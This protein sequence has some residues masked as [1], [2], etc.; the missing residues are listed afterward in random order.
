MTDA[1]LAAKQN[2]LWQMIR[3]AK[4]AIMR[5][6]RNGP[7]GSRDDVALVQAVFA[8]V[9][10]KIVAAEIEVRELERKAT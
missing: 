7:N 3:D 2:E 8:H 4:S 1:Q 5:I 10:G 9:M 6:A